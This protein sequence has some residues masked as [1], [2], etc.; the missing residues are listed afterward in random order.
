MTWT[1]LERP[2]RGEVLALD[3]D[4]EFVGR[5]QGIGHENTEGRGTIE[6]DD[7]ESGVATEW[8]KGGAESGK[9]VFTAGDF[10]L[11]SRQVEVTRDQPEV[12]EARGDDDLRNFLQ[13]ENRAV[14]A[15]V[16]DGVEPQSAGRIGLRI[17]IDQQNTNA[18]HSQAGC[19][20]NGGGRLADAAFLVGHSDDFHRGRGA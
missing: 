15:V 10:D 9:V 12:L 5:R 3:R 6:Q 17:K 19:E 1:I 11:S 18:A 16:V 20:V 13:T 2:S 4:K 7:I 8:L 14:D